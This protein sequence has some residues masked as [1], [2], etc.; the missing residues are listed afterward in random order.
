M[1]SLN[2]SLILN[3]KCLESNDLM[4]AFR[5]VLLVADKGYTYKKN[6]KKSDKNLS[7]YFDYLFSRMYMCPL[8]LF[9]TMIEMRLLHSPIIKI[10]FTIENQLQPLISYCLYYWC[11]KWV[12][13]VNS[14]VDWFFSIL[15]QLLLRLL[16]EDM[17]VYWSH[18]RL[19]CI[20]KSFKEEMM[21]NSVWCKW[22]KCL[23]LLTNWDHTL[24]LWE[25]Y[26]K[27]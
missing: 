11:K 20:R 21:A 23:I 2:S 26:G 7:K 27:I 25:R 19:Q 6:L 15:F 13:L 14:W 5:W 18:Q 24:P 1:L 17:G 8:V 4:F 22:K 9:K 3:V 12:N 16:F 10:F